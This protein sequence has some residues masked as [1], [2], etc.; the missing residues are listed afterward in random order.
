M[1][2]NAKKEEAAVMTPVCVC[3]MSFYL[4]LVVSYVL[5][6]HALLCP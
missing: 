1:S 4:C 3:F 6:F 2:L 5:I